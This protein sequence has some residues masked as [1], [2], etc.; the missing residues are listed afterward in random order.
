MYEESSHIVASN[1][2]ALN[3]MGFYSS[4]NNDLTSMMTISHVRSFHQK[5]DCVLMLAL[6]PWMSDW[7]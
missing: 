7:L 5:D 3:I 1:F 2:D 6:F 4:L